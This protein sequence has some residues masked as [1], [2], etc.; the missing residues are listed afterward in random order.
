M[1]IKSLIK[2]KFLFKAKCQNNN[3]IPQK[4]QR[5]LFSQSLPSKVKFRLHAIIK[6][7]YAFNWK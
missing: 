7:L 4:E 1:Q 2:S 6:L 3:G 5:M